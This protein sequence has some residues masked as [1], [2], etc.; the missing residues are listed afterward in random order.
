MKCRFC[1]G[2]MLPGDK[3]PLFMDDL[4][5]TVKC[6]CC[7]SCPCLVRQPGT[8]YEPD[9]FAL[10]V[11][12]NG[13][14]YEVEQMYTK[15]DSKEPPLFSVFKYVFYT[16]EFKED[17]IKSEFVLEVNADVKATPQ[18]IHSKLATILTFS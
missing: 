18:N 8:K 7:Y 3:E 6:W 12:Y 4:V 9:W 13:N 16:N 5:S 17:K 14:W 2:T 11:Q 1:Q 15:P 10:I